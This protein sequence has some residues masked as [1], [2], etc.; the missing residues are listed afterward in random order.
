ME[1]DDE[2]VYGEPGQ[3]F[4]GMKNCGIREPMLKGVKKSNPAQCTYKG[5]R[6]PFFIVT[7]GKM[8]VFIRKGVF[9]HRIQE[10]LDERILQPRVLFFF[11]TLG[12]RISPFQLSGRTN[13]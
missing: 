11:T 13:F 5:R 1:S 12:Q 8:M 6:V 2:G 7:R 9:S 10:F 3:V 4:W